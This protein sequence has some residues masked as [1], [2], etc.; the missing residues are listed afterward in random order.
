M[1]TEIQSVL[2]DKNKWT[3][4]TAHKWLDRHNLYPLKSAHTTLHFIRYRIENPK[5]YR[6]FV[7]KKLFRG[8]ELVLGVK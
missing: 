7:T 6:R 3:K 1:P 2:F 5:K 8:I 4:K